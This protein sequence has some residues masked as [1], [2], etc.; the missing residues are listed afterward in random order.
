MALEDC[1]EEEA[2]LMK[3]E[4]KTVSLSKPDPFMLDAIAEGQ[5]DSFAESYYIGDMPD[6]MIAAKKSSGGYKAVGMI[7]SAPDKESLAKELKRAGADTIIENFKQL[8]DF[9]Q[10]G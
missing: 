4:A 6:D 3:A 2:R 8:I 9:V 7:M 10:S 1:L 5:K